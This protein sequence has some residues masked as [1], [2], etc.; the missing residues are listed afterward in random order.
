MRYALI[1]LLLLPQLAFAGPAVHHGRVVGDTL[2]WD[3]YVA[4][5]ARELA[6]ATPVD[7]ARL[8]AK[9]RGGEPLETSLDERGRVRSV[10]LTGGL[11]T[12]HLQVDEPLTA[13][14][15]HPPLVAQDD[16]QRVTVSGGRFQPAP[17]THLG[18]FVRSWGEEDLSVSDRHRLDRFARQ[19]S[20]GTSRGSD[21][22]YLHADALDA[23]GVLAGELKLGSPIRSSAIAASA[24]ALGLLLLAAYG[25]YRQLG[26]AAQRER[27]AWYIEH[28]LGSSSADPEN[29]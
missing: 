6:L 18:R 12:V 13:H 19:V 17:S 1:V 16:L 27:N 25:L 22:I 11:T 5:S 20:A 4:T 7:A 29:G 28:E 3:S 24:G 10:R 21:A 14:T 8:Q 23:Q 15:L 2:R 26:Q 9:G